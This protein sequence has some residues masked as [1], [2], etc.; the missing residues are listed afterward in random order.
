MSAKPTEQVKDL[1]FN[2]EG[3]HQIENNGKR[4]VYLGYKS[5]G[6]FESLG[7]LWLITVID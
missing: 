5:L 6:E 4:N 3:K 7:C 2:Q 1:F